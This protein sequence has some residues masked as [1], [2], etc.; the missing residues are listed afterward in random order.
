MGLRKARIIQTFEGPT[1]KELKREQAGEA[2][3]APRSP[4]ATRDSRQPG[5]EVCCSVLKVLRENAPRR[6]L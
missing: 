4:A 3:H 5:P 2:I 6:F 1:H